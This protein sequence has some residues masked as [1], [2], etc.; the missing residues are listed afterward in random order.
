MLCLA[1]W[2]KS[3]TVLVVVA[4]II[5]IVLIVLMST[6]KPGP[7]SPD[8]AMGAELRPEKQAEVEQPEGETPEE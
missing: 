7:E 6:R 3:C 4:V 5:L 1:E 8:E 2:N